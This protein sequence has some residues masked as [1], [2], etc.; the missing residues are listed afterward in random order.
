[1]K[2]LVQEQ[3]Y[4]LL[5]YSCSSSRPIDTVHQEFSK[6]NYQNNGFAFT[7]DH[8]LGKKGHPVRSAVLKTQIGRLVV[9]S[10]TTGESLLLYV[11][12]FCP[13]LWCCG[14]AESQLRRISPC[15]F[16][17]HC[18]SQVQKLL[19]ISISRFHIGWKWACV[20]PSF[21][22]AKIEDTVVLYCLCVSA[23]TLVILPYCFGE[24]LVILPL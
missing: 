24:P 6:I 11:L 2:R 17:V 10:V 13:F 4:L 12:S 16:V 23:W 19:G 8:R 5:S 14:V 18:T 20:R 9:R 15:S 7:Y 21:A 3:F 22:K 1:M